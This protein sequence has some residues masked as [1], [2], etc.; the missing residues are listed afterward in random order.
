[1][2][3]IKQKKDLFVGV[4]YGDHA[5]EACFA[6]AEDSNLS[7]IERIRRTAKMFDFFSSID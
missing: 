6:L 2:E 3:E 5:T 7:L 4:D 1:M